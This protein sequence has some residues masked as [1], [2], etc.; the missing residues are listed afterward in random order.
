MGCL[1]C[2]VP[3]WKQD[4]GVKLQLLLGGWGEDVC[5]VMR[6]RYM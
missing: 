1:I 2:V 6:G 3:R 5:Q 4:E